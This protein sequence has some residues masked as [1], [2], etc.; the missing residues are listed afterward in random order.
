MEK[1]ANSGHTLDLLWPIRKD[2]LHFAI[3]WKSIIWGKDRQ[4]RETKMGNEFPKKQTTWF[5]EHKK[6]LYT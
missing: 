4:T 6:Y 1:S 2:K 3:F 5:L